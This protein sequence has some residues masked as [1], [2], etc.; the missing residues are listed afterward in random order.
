M[1]KLLKSEGRRA[2]LHMFGGR[3]A[4]VRGL[5]VIV[6]WG[7][8]EPALV[9]D[10]ARVRNDLREA[11]HDPVALQNRLDEERIGVAHYPQIASMKLTVGMS[12]RKWGLDLEARK[13]DET[14]P[15]TLEVRIAE[16]TW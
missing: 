7:N 5:G 10:I 8:A 16:T 4:S 12:G 2:T 9:V 15:R 13:K 11:F 6:V 14:N 1:R 3:W